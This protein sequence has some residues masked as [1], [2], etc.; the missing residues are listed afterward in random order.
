MVSFRVKVI[1]HVNTN[2]ESVNMENLF[3]LPFLWNAFYGHGR[4]IRDRRRGGH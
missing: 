1:L 2:L 4:R 3:G